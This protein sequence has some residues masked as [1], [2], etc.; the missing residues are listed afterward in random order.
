MIFNI[1]VHNSDQIA[2]ATYQ[3]NEGPAS[4]PAGSLRWQVKYLP[5]FK[6]SHKCCNNK[7]HPILFLYIEIKHCNTQMKVK[8]EQM[9]VKN[10]RA[11][12]KSF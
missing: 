1:K 8:N 5:T 4:K 11:N 3:S 7:I 10:E 6:A 12:E 9:K 2:V